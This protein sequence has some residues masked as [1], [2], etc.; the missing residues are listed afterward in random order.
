MDQETPQHPRLVGLQLDSETMK[1]LES[2]SKESLEQLPLPITSARPLGHGDRKKV[3]TR[4]QVMRESMSALCGKPFIKVRPHFLRNSKTNRCLELDA[5]NEEL[6]LACEFHGIQ[7]YQHLNPF[8]ET[9]EEFEAQLDRDRLKVTLCKRHGVRLIVVPHTVH[10]ESI[11]RF[12]R[13]QLY[14]NTRPT[15]AC[16]RNLDSLPPPGPV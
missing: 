13:F 7:H 8:H 12:L 11:E 6:K 1:E 14:P 16:V 9:E 4:E 3:G 10:K 2:A 15:P 5:Y